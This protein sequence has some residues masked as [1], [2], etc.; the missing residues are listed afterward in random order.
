MRAAKATP[1]IYFMELGTDLLKMND[2][3]GKT[4]KF[5]HEG[6]ECKECHQD[7]PLYRMGFCKKCFFESPY[8]S[9]TIIRPELSRAHLGIEERNLDIE[10]EIQL[11]PHVVY[12]SYTGDVKVGVTRKSNIPSRWVDQGATF[13]TI[14][15]ETPNRYEAGVIEAELKKHISDSTS[16]RKMLESTLEEEPDFQK[17]ETALE[18]YWPKNSKEFAV[19][20]KETYRLDYPYTPPAKINS[21][22][23]DKN[24]TFDGVLEGIKGQYLSF[25]N[26]GQ[27]NV[28][29][30]EGYV[31]R[32]EMTT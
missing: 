12:L 27:L 5:S 24:P 31:V 10:K 28:Y 11:Q 7:I 1:L 30:H 21:I 17:F 18:E 26:M 29:A 3:F 22:K 4:L 32:L 15:A 2:L 8:A 13:A 20:G 25:K 16:W 9:E 23:L 6:Y 14:I 19:S